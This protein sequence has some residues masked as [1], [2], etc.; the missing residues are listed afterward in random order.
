MTC[1]PVTVIP[2]VI[3]GTVPIVGIEV[4]AC[5]KLPLVAC[6][7]R[8]SFAPIFGR[9]TGRSASEQLTFRSAS[10]MAASDPK[11]V[12]WRTLAL[13]ESGHSFR[14]SPRLKPID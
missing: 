5:G 8:Y 1:E 10:L 13:P 3:P 12:V 2:T 4:S 14:P 11:P 7:P 6:L 9:A